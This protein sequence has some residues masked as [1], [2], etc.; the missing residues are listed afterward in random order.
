MPPTRLR[1]GDQG[2]PVRAYFLLRLAINGAPQGP[3]WRLMQLLCAPSSM[4]GPPVSLQEG[5]EEIIGVSSVIEIVLSEGP[6]L[7]E[8]KPPDKTQRRLV[9]RRHQSLYPVHF[10]DAERVSDDG[11]HRFCHNPLAPELRVK[12]VA[13]LDLGRSLVPFVESGRAYEFSAA[14]QRDAPPDASVILEVVREVEL[15][16][17]PCGF[18]ILRSWA[19]L[20]VHDL[21]GV[22]VL[23]VPRG[24]LRRDLA[25]DQSLGPQDGE[26]SG[27][28][29]APMRGVNIILSI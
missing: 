20:P 11:R 29:P 17:L 25:K 18:D 24:V 19:F 16:L 8:S 23:E 28:R 1:R 21:P 27:H 6:L 14:L 22:V 26:F 13:G 12:V 2:S 4:L 5:E 3:F 15:E 7:S 10:H 9:P